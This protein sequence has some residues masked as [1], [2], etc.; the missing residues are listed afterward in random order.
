MCSPYSFTDIRNSLKETS[1]SSIVDS[2][3]RTSLVIDKEIALTLQ[4][5]LKKFIYK[6]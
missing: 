3:N 4:S 6:R 5:N 1:E 2:N